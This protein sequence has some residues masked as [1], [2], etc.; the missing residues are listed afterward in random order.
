MLERKKENEENLT[1]TQSGYVKIKNLSS[2]V[3]R[4]KE[5]DEENGN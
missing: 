2:L 1:Y 4:K 3:E 5:W